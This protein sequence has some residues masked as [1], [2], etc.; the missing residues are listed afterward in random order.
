MGPIKKHKLLHYL[1]MIF[2][3]SNVN[4]QVLNIDREDGNDSIKKKVKC[5]SSFFFSSD[6]Q[7]NDL[8]DF[9]NTTEIDY[10]LKKERV[11]IFLEQVEMSF[12]GKKAL[13]NNGY[14]QTRFRDNDTRKIY[15]DY[16]A[17][18]QWNGIQGMEH[19]GLGGVN[20]RL[21][22]MEKTK[23]DLY[24]S[25]GVFYESEKW[26]PFLTE[27]SFPSDSLQIVNR[28]LIRLN[29]SAKFA[30]KLSENID[31]AGS[32]FLQFPFNSYFK[33]PRWF[34]DV[35]LNFTINKY[36][37][38]MIHYDHNFD[39]YRPLPISKYFYNLNTGLQIKI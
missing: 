6:K 29:T 34:I 10:F 39:S 5:S 9:T 4:S 15:P 25:I 16:F 27:F 2:I 33:N 18:Y 3:V 1:M 38:F 31:F 14:F 32:T 13:E 35:N 24:T 37:S 17:Q 20:L 22:W 23:S 19:R 12:A 28:N 26:N 7:K 21:R 8:I 30:I 11:I 36:L